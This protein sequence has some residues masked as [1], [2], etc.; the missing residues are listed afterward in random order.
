MQLETII[1]MQNQMTLT[2]KGIP[3]LKSFAKAEQLQD[4]NEEPDF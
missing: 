3:D 2:E 4:L 1:D